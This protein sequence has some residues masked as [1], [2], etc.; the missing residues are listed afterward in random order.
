M[1][2]KG[3]VN[4]MESKMSNFVGIMPV[5]GL[6]KKKHCPNRSK[7]FSSQP[8]SCSFLPKNYGTICSSCK[9]FYLLCESIHLSTAFCA[10]YCLNSIL[11]ILIG[12]LFLKYTL[13]CAILYEIKIAALF[14]RRI[15]VRSGNQ[16]FRKFTA[17]SFR[18]QRSA[19]S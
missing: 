14:E 5:I 9:S 6:R 8:Y 13:N 19:L 1:K 16:T 10:C 4:T 12:F 15:G 2:E 7:M 18:H 11:F 17:G 3:K